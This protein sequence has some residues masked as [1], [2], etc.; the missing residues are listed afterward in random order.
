MTGALEWR[1]NDA[2]RAWVRGSFAEFNDDE[3][4]D[5]LRFTYSD[6]TIAAGATDSAATFNNARIYKALRHREQ[7]NQ[8]T[9]LNG[10]L[11]H[12][13]GNGAILDATLAF[14]RS[15]QTYPH[16]DEL[17]YRSGAQTLSYDTADHYSPTYS[18]FNSSYYLTPGNYS[19]REN[20]FRSNTTEQRDTSFRFNVELP[21]AIGGRDVTWKFG[22]KFSS[23]D[24]F[25]DEERYRDRTATAP[26][27]PG[28]LAALLS[29]RES[30]NY[31]YGLGVK[32]DHGLVGDY[33]DQVRAL[34]TNAASRR[35][36]QS[37][38]ADYTAEEEITAGYGSARFDL[39][40]TNILVGLRVEN[41]DFKAGSFLAVASTA[42]GNV[43]GYVQ[44]P[45]S[46]SRDR[47][48]WFPNLTLRHAFSDDLIG[49]FALTR[50][51]SRP[52]YVDVVPRVLETTDGGR[53]TVSRG[54]PDLEATL[55][56]NVDAGLEY[57]LRPLGVV[58]VNA[59]YKDLEDFRYTLVYD[60]PYT[61]STGTVT[62]N[63]TEALNAPEGH[64][65]GVEFNWQQTFDFLPGW[66]SGFGVFANYTLTDAEIETATAYAGRNTFVLPGQS[67]ETWNA[68]LFYENSGFSARISYTHRSEF[69]EAI[70]AANAG[71]DLYVEGR[72]QLDFTTSYD[73][74]NGVELFGE[75][76][77]LTDSAGVRYYGSQ[78]RT[79]EYEKFGYNVFMG[80]RFKL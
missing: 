39:G 69:L 73:F 80:V 41:T 51:I 58:S 14:A 66:A 35:I 31:D 2:S 7:D 70:N 18:A 47:T 76:K 26:V 27:N 71:L 38:T 10:G 55:S 56:N 75:A 28:A 23:R 57:Y 79:Y 20:T 22:G 36:P 21:S 59:Y 42:A 9:T 63:I 64:L 78:E 50:A 8:I 32:F 5:T 40:A 49:R 65:A 60:G 12:T 74:G 61:T 37:W 3:Y 77:N 72:G 52:D 44:S 1:P 29:D 19:F 54:N 53:V 46:V 45:L 15:E 33:L 16:R 13:F 48:D 34:S 4:R 6:G 62:A 43:Q 11:E 17:V 24:V 25:A 30:R 68:A 67:D